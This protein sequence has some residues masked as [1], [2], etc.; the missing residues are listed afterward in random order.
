MSL[1]R[2][3]HAF[4]DDFQTAVCIAISVANQQIKQSLVTHCSDPGK[5]MWI[6]SNR[7]YLHY[8]HEY[9]TLVAQTMA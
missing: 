4:P 3:N 1:C 8:V 5:I 9:K 6:R 7:A 2:E